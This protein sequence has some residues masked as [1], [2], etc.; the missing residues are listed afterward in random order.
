MNQKNLLTF[1]HRSESLLQRR[2]KTA[3]LKTAVAVLIEKDIEVQGPGLPPW[4]LR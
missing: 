2:L 1:D 4:D 3:T